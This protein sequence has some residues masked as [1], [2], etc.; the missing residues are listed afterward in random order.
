MAFSSLRALVSSPPPPGGR[1]SVIRLEHAVRFP[2]KDFQARS[3]I[4]PAKLV[5]NISRRDA[6]TCLSATLLATFL[7]TEPAEARSVKP[8]TRRKI[9]EK[10]DKLREKAGV[11]KEKM[12]SSPDK[13]DRLPTSPSNS[14]NLPSVEATL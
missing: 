7:W 5:G 6:M 9:R 12:E 8:E 2:D 11:P 3:K 10:L 13:K 4:R 14:L 1:D